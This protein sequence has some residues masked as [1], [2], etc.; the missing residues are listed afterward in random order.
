MTQKELKQIAVKYEALRK[1][2]A[3]RN[4]RWRKN[5]PEYERSPERRAYKRDWRLKKQGKVLVAA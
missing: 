5:H 3:E 4:R 1:S 2:R